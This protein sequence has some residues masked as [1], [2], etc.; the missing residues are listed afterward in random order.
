MFLELFLGNVSGACWRG[1]RRQV[2]EGDSLH[3]LPAAVGP[4]TT[5]AKERGG[6][7]LD[8]FESFSLDTSFLTPRT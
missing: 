4:P 7:N 6:G 3:V 5:V 8:G 2:C 1:R